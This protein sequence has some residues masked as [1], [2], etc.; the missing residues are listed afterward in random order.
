LHFAWL[1]EECTVDIYTEVLA[2]ISTTD[3]LVW[4]TFTP[5]LG[6]SEVVRRFLLDKASGREV[7][8]MTIDDVGHF[9]DEQRAQ[10][11]AQYPAHER[12]ARV[13]GVPALGSGRIFPVDEALIAC[14]P[15]EFPKHWARIGGCDFGWDHPAAFVELV[16]DR[17]LDTIYVA[18]ALRIRE[19][20]PVLHAAAIRP[21]GAKLP[22]A[23]PRDGRRETLEGAGIA[24]S[25]QYEA[26]GLN[27][28]GTHAQ[29]VDGSVSVEA[30]LM[31]MLDRM[32]TGRFKVLKHLYDWFE[33]FRLYHRKEGRVVKEGDD[34]MS[35]TRYAL[36]MLR[37]AECERPLPK[38]KPPWWRP[39][40]SAGGTWMAN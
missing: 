17:D 1:D 9:S 5:L 12:E 35:A 38:K 7:I 36:M 21:W 19:A 27:M 33:E 39:G 15:I 18:R 34:L 6:V 32:Q 30:G 16:W 4:T 20:T 11:I 3:G 40:W 8:T 23:W 25:R 24:L 26:Q 10:I 14:E 13:R 37:Y 29:F 22:W 31:D 2:R 28:L